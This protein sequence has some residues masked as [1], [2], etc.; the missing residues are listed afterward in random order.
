MQQQPDATTATPQQASPAGGGSLQLSPASLLASVV[1]ARFSSPGA[2]A[3]A[4]QGA[5]DAV[6]SPLQQESPLPPLL[7]D[8][9]AADAAAELALEVACAQPE[10]FEQGAGLGQQQDLGQQQRRRQQQQQQPGVQGQEGP[11]AGEQLPEQQGAAPEAM[12]VDGVADLLV[13][14]V[15][16]FFE[17]GMPS[18]QGQTLLQVQEAQQQQGQQGQEQQPDLA[19]RQLVTPEPAVAQEGQQEAE[20]QQQQQQQQQAPVEELI[21]KSVWQVFSQS[22][23]PAA[24]SPAATFRALGPDHH[25]QLLPER[26]SGSGSLTPGG[27]GGADSALLTPVTTSGGPAAMGGGPAKGSSAQRALAHTSAFNS[28]SLGAAGSSPG[29]C[30]PQHAIQRSGGL[31]SALE[32]PLEASKPGGWSGLAGLPEMA[33]AAAAAAAGAPRCRFLRLVP[34][35][36]RLLPEPPAA[37]AAPPPS[38]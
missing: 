10:P 31:S 22:Q 8:P 27:P 25:Q 15:W 23:Q 5:R 12:D 29:F 20:Q 3:A 33:A 13:E 18:G 36:C 1:R 7:L 38:C 11:A 17:A 24:S 35:A 26:P 37:P 30:T 2:A 34:R 16:S 19:A 9:A 32:A 4:T 14:S 6:A 21:L 28:A